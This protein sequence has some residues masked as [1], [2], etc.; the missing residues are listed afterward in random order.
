MDVLIHHA[1]LSECLLWDILAAKVHQIPVVMYAH[2]VFSYLLQS[3]SIYYQRQ[4]FQMQHIYHL[5]DAVITLS[6]TNKAYWKNFVSTVFTMCNP[7]TMH[8]PETPVKRVPHSMLCVGRISPEKNMIHAVEILSI[9]RKQVKDATLT[10]VGTADESGADYMNRLVSRVKELGLESAVTFAGFHAEVAEFYMAA[11]VYLCTSSYEGFSL[12]IAESK[13]AGIPCVMYDMPYLIFAK[14]GKGIISVPQNDIG[15]AANA[16]IALMQNPDEYQRLASEA[17]ESASLLD[18]ALLE[19]AWKEVF[20]TLEK[21]LPLWKPGSTPESIMV[22]T[23]MDNLYASVTT[24]VITHTPPAAP[25][26][27]A[28]ELLPAMLRYKGPGKKLVTLFYW[29][30]QVFFAQFPSQVTPKREDTHRSPE[31]ESVGLEQQ[32]PTLAA[33]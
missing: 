33:A 10:I 14:Q 18:N 13:V 23:L 9:V 21:E 28:S 15:A 22:R 27:P 20:S 6:D 3:D 2:S 25:D 29:F 1:W 8:L 5:V 16:L 4:F 12:S 30:R 19:Y 32:P 31:P 11:E 7:C 17:K 24:R 26:R